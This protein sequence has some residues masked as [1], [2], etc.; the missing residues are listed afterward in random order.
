[1]KLREIGA[2]AYADRVLPLTASL[3]GRH[4]PFEAY[5]ARTSEL[6]RSAYGRRNYKTLGLFIAN[7]MVASFKRYLRSASCRF[8]HVPFRCVP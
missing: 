5:V 1:M 8:L 6:A 4:I 7:E 2:A 3:W